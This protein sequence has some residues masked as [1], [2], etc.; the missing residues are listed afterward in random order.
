MPA[1]LSITATA[2]MTGTDTH[3]AIIALSGREMPVSYNSM[4]VYGKEPQG[5]Y[6]SATGRASADKIPEHK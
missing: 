6:K 4:S 3:S 1:M 5:T 2:A